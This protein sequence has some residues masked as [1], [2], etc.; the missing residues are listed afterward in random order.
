MEKC[1]VIC[2]RFVTL[3]EIFIVFTGFWI[4]PGNAN[5]YSKKLY[6]DLV[7]KPFKTNYQKD[8]RPVR[9]GNDTIMV[10]LD[11]RLSQIV[12]L[13]SYREFSFL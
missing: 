4:L 8:I 12:D 13:V 10:S 9:A 1:S 2:P 6:Q 11:L 7:S 3:L 5:L